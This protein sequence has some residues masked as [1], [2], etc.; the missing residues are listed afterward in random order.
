MKTIFFDEVI[1]EFPPNKYVDM[2]QTY[3]EKGLDYFNNIDLIFDDY[4]ILG[5][6]KEVRFKI[7]EY[8]FI[9]FIDSTS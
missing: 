6:E 4:E 8:D 9:G 1:E 5:V 3:Y 2:Q 7:D